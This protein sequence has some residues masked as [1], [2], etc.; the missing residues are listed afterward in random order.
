LTQPDKVIDAL[1]ACFKAQGTT[2]PS[3][4]LQALEG[5]WYLD[6]PGVCNDEPGITEGLLAFDRSRLVG[7]E[8][9]CKIVSSES[10]DNSIRMKMACN[11][12]GVTS[13][14]FT[15]IEFL[16]GDRIK[17][18]ERN[19]RKM[20]SSIHHRCSTIS[21]VSQQPEKPAVEPVIA[22]AS[23]KAKPSIRQLDQA[24]VAALL[25]AAER[26]VPKPNAAPE[27]HEQPV[28]G[29]AS[30][31]AV[32]Q[33]QVERCWKKPFVAVNDQNLEA[34]F[35]IRL[36]RDGTLETATVSESKPATANLRLYEKAALRA[37]VECQPYSLL[38]ERFDE[39]K[40][41]SPVFT[42]RKR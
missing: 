39:W 6:N 29:S 28:R 27:T 10:N 18:S 17:R 31:S 15:T 35:I 4:S 24:K 36:K 3:A 9:D 38:A 13:Q 30:W 34:A 37:I 33:K 19:G 14:A 25:E 11:G 1:R 42:E 22:D 23:S 41:F 20:Y 8:N 5:K 16:G 2:I 12:E 7:L 32:F 26:N 21:V 40:N